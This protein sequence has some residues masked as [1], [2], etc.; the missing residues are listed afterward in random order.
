LLPRLSLSFSPIPRQVWTSITGKI[1]GARTCDSHALVFQPRV[2]LMTPPLSFAPASYLPTRLPHPDLLLMT[3][4]S[5]TRSL[6]YRRRLAVKPDSL[7]HEVFSTRQA[8]IFLTSMPSTI[9]YMK[10]IMLWPHFRLFQ[11]RIGCQHRLPRVVPFYTSP[12]RF[13]EFLGHCLS[14]ACHCRALLP[15]NFS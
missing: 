13:L 3:L 5:G 12:S 1:D 8:C 15:L 11:P 14:Y 7:G 2:G 6:S 10:C 4:H 9:A